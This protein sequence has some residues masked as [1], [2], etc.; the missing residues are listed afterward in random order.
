M[1][2]SNEKKRERYWA[3]R[4]RELDRKR[5]YAAANPERVRAQSIERL[6]KERE[7]R[8]LT[9]DEARARHKAR[10]KATWAAKMAARAQDPEWIA[11]QE[12]MRLRRSERAKA[13][14]AANR[15]RQ[16]ELVRKW[17]SE[18]PDKARKSKRRYK[19]RKRGALISELSSLQRGRCAYCR[20]KLTLAGTHIDHIHPRAKGGLNSRR[21]YQL[22]CA[23]CNISK[24]AK[25][26][27]AFSQERGMLL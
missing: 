19:I 13:W 1:A 6:R 25:D 15:D 10:S 9:S 18:N 12:S 4:D 3:N 8:A 2:D 24:S 21:N 22:A 11:H 16:R 27:I 5:R 17:K 26:P 20:E 7:A 14:R 23:P